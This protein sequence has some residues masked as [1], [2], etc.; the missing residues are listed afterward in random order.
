MHFLYN[1]LSRKLIDN[2]FFRVHRLHFYFFSILTTW[3]TQNWPIMDIMHKNK[4]LQE[5]YHLITFN[6][7]VLSLFTFDYM[8]LR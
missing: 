8:R 2:I 5:T 1:A 4:L 6:F 3:Y 7:C